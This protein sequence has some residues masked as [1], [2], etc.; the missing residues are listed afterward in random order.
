MTTLQHFSVFPTQP[1]DAFVSGWLSHITDTG[2]P[3]TYENIT[4][5]HPPKDGKVV[6]LSGEIKVPVLRREGQEWV[7][8]PICSPTSPQFKVGRM[9][10]Y[11][12]EQAVRFIGHNCAAK[13]HGELYAEAEERFKVDARCRQLIAAWSSL[14]ERRQ[15]LLELI[16]QARPVAEAQHFVREQIDDQAPGFSE[17]LYTDLSRRQGVISIKNDTGVRDQKGQVVL[18]TVVLGTVYGYVFLKKGFAPQN[19]LREAKAFLATMDSPLPPWSPGGTDDAATTEILTR[20]DQAL[21]M[22]KAVRETVALVGSSR[23]FFDVATLG[24]LERWARNEQSPFRSLTFGRSGN[25]LLLRSD[26]FAGQHFA[27][28]ILPDAALL[29]LQYRP[30]ALDPLTSERPV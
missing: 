5:T 14:V 6:L 29:S 22:M 16:E 15:Y 25:Q 18:E 11:P 21:K 3:E 28:A 30:T 23:M 7:P 2:Y 27:N 8:C 24:L 20:G 10:Y 12:E 17:F 26:T 13:H 9:A 1:D 19:V 4:T